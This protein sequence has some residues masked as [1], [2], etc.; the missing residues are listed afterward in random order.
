MIALFAAIAVGVVVMLCCVI[1]AFK[2]REYKEQIYY[3]K[4]EIGR[5]DDPVERRHWEHQLKKQYA[6]M[7]PFLRLRKKK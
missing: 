5:S 2:I 3:Y 7:N 6:R 1:G 4:M